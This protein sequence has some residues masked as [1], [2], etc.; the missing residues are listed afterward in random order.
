MQTDQNKIS[1]LL[2]KPVQYILPMFQRPYSW[3]EKQWKKLWGD[4]VDILRNPQ[5]SEHFLGT[6]VVLQEDSLPGKPPRFLL[7]DGQQR[8]TTFSLILSALRD[9][10]YKRDHESALAKK[11]ENRFLIDK[12]ETDDFR[13]KIIPTQDDRQPYKTI[14]LEG[15]RL[16]DTQIE[17]CYGFFLKKIGELITRAENPDLFFDQMFSLFSDSFILVT[18]QLSKGENAYRIFESLNATGLSLTQADL[19]RNYVFM[20]LSE[21]PKEQQV[22]LY[23]SYWHPIEQNLTDKLTV[24]RSNIGQFTAFLRHYLATSMGELAN[25]SDVYFETRSRLDKEFAT[26]DNLIEELKR[27][28]KFSIFYDR[29]LK[30]EL[31]ETEIGT[32][33][34]RLKLLDYSTAF[35]FLLQV[36]ELLDASIISEE[37]V[38]SVLDCLENYMVRRYLCN[39][40]TNYMNKM[41][42]VLFRS[43]DASNMVASLK[44]ALASRNY[45]RDHRIREIL[46]KIKLYGRSDRLDKLRIVLESIEINEWDS[47]DMLPVFS[48]AVSVEHILPQTPTEDWK[49]EVGEGFER[50][51]SDLCDTIGNLTL[52]GY[53]S[54]LG[55]RPFKD[56]KEMLA[57]SEFKLNQY[58]QE[59]SRWDERAILSRSKALAEESISIWPEFDAVFSVVEQVSQKPVKI[60]ILQDEFEVRSWRDVAFQVSEYVI[61]SVGSQFSEIAQS[62]PR[63]FNPNPS[64]ES[65]D[66]SRVRVLS[67]GWGVYVDLSAKNVQKF[68]T[69]LLD[70]SGVDSSNFSVELQ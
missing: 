55:N 15:T 23:E 30:P 65:L 36:F 16:H 21:L 41:F 39:E 53:N 8:L 34:Q 29:F 52:T 51:H 28:H 57:M 17:Q 47:K 5:R 70:T 27:I 14:I 24:G 3:E 25:I 43:V 32:R 64:R 20:R 54:E 10:V 13:F 35:P 68:T 12:D 18:I 45:P 38:C 63:Y 4:I 1:A 46:P 61:R 6:I 56:K 31:D 37:E 7:I 19:V 58:F 59:I 40:P 50:V 69:R 60:K 48:S 33:L 66:S 22:G 62:F 11:I 49:R 44:E 2:G 42:A 67:N 9:L 26:T